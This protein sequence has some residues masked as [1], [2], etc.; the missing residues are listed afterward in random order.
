MK[1]LV[2]RFSAL[3]DVAMT[4]PVVDSLA[5]ANPQAD[6]TVL[7]RPFVQPLFARMPANVHFVGVDLKQYKGMGGL[8]RLFR[9]LGRYDAVADLHDVLR[10]QV[11]RCFFRLAGTRTAH[12][13]KGR[14]DRKTLVRPRHK[15]RKQLPT[16]FQRYADVFRRLGLPV[17]PAGFRSIYGDGK[18]DIRPLRDF[19]GDRDGQAWIGFAPF[20]A[21]RG[22]QLPE[23]TS[24]ALIQ[25]LAGRPDTRLFLFGG[26]ADAPLLEQWTAG[27]PHEVTVVAGRLT[28]EQELALMSHLDVMVSMDSANMHLASL[29]GTPVVSVW[30]ATY[31]L[32]GFLGWKQ[33]AEDCIQADGLDCRPCSIFGNKPCL[34]SDY[35]CLASLTP[36]SIAAKIEQI[37]TQKPH[38]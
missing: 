16:S 33:R 28:L 23:A 22:K 8:Y 20:A 7:S 36:D 21:H 17:D 29:A 34:R 38:P 15:I 30:G 3:G 2:I 32:A 25:R 19:T 35:A 24:A 18:G 27:H 12:I 6:I 13:D 26:K 14:R 37:L 4:V 9:R 11:L 10:T 1:L 31:P 5:R